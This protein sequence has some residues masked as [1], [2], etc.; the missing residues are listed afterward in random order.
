[1]NTRLIYLQIY[2]SAIILQ[3]QV[4][5]QQWVQQEQPVLREH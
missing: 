1:V 5:V 2:F 4:L 3:E